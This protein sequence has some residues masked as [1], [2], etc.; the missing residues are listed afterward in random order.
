ML[1]D[2]L[3]K[4]KFQLAAKLEEVRS[5]IR[6]CEDEIRWLQNAPLVLSEALQ[7]IDRFVTQKRQDLDMRP[8]FSDADQGIASHPLTASGRA[9]GGGYGRVVEGSAVVIP[10]SNVD[11]SGLLCSLFPDLIKKVL[12]GQAERH[13]EEHEAGPPLSQR[14]QL[15]EAA[16][17]RHHTLE[18]EEEALISQ[19]DA[20]GLDG[21]FR[22]IDVNPEV[23]L[24]KEA[25]HA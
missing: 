9:E 5:E 1:N 2:L 16:K 22:R 23:V 12:A 8:F 13:A 15:I 14:P 19:A 3:A 24:M 4:T 25:D 20:A 10:L 21:F 18:V 17:Q 7:N 11:L 6:E